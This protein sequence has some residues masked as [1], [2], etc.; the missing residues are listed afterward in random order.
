M[1]VDLTFEIFRRMV[2]EYPRSEL[3]LI[4][5]TCRM[6]CDPVLRVDV[7]RATR[8]Y[9]RELSEQEATLRRIDPDLDVARRIVGSNDFADLLRDEGIEPPVKVSPAWLKKPEDERDP[10]K[11]IAYAFA[12]DDPGMVALLEHPKPNVRALA[13]ARLA[14]KSTGNVNKAKRFLLAAEGGHALPV[15]LSYYRAHTGRFGGANKMNLQNMERGGELRKCILAPPD[16][17]ILVCDSAQIEARVNAWLWDQLDMLEQFES[18]D[19][20]CDFASIVY[21]RRITKDDKTERFVG[22][23]AVLGLGYQ[24]GALKFQTTLAKGTMGTV[25][26]LPFNLCNQ[27]V[28]A[29]RAKNAQIAQGWKVCQAIIEDMAAGKEG[30]YKCLLWGKEYI[31]LPNGMKLKYPGLKKV[32]GDR[33]EEWAYWPKGQPKKIYGGLLCENIVQALARI[34]ITDQMLEIDECARVVMMCHDEIVAVAHT[35]NAPAVYDMMVAIMKEAPSWCSGL[36]LNAEGGWA[37]NYSK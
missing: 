7:E 8:E 37:P 27:I 20:Y 22:K 35:E 4:D 15:G 36:P 3:D 32:K 25:V 34:I 19:P 33:Y 1:D 29:Y 9:E 31:L 5:L 14:V 2:K 16:H 11:K 6:F 21:R 10:D 13:Q 30:Q 24:M 17:Q 26:D 28:K 23:V 18:S 12:K